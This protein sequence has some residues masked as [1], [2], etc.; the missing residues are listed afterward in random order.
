MSALNAPEVD[1]KAV[2]LRPDPEWL[3]LV[4]SI[5]P[6]RHHDNGHGWRHWAEL[7]SCQKHI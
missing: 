1:D 7:L 2:P 5:Y 3:L 4:V 6:L